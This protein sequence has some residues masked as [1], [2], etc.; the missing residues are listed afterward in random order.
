MSPIVWATAAYAEVMSCI[1]ANAFP[2]GER[3]GSEALAL[4][5]ELPGAFGFVASEGGFVMA[6]VAADEAEILTLAV[7]PAFQRRGVGRRLLEQA[8]DEAAARGA[9]VMFLEV[10]ARN[11]PAQ[12]LYTACGFV[13]IGRRARYYAGDVDALV[14]RALIPFGSTAR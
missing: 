10:S 9:G 11:R 3:W 5:L 6:R 14:L 2:P 1:H 13:E 12:A 7:D 8:G 4:Q